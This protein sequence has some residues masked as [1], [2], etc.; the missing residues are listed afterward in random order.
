[1]AAS[2][3]AWIAISVFALGTILLTVRGA[4]RTSSLS[5]FA[6]GNRDIPAA[7][8]GLSLT[9]Q[10]TSVATFVIN[11]GLVFHYGLAGLLGLGVAA[12]SGI[13]LGLVVFTARF[14]RVGNQ[15]AALTVPQW[16]GTRFGS[17]RLRASF[18]LLSL[19]L[20][21]YAVLIVVAL[22]IVLGGLL[23]LE[24]RTVAVA[25]TV[26]VVS[27][28][29]IGG[30]NTHA[31][32]NAAQAVVMLGV[33]L[34]LIGWGLPSLWRDGGLLATI[35]AQDANLV[36]VT[37]P[38]SPYFRNLL[39]VFGCNFLVGLA[40]VCQP[41]IVSKALYLRDERQVRTFLGVAVVAGLVFL[42]V[43]VIG[44]Y[45]RAVVPVTTPIDEVVPAYIFLSFPP[46]LQVVIGVGL[47]CAGLSTL[48]GILLA[49][50]S[51]FSID[52]HPLLARWLPASLV[53]QGDRAALRFGRAALA[54]VAVVVILLARAQITN[55]TGGSVA[56]FAQYGVYLLFT[57]SFLPL[58]CGMFAPRLQSTWVGLGVAVSVLAYVAVAALQLTAMHNN[59]AFLASC[60]IVSGWAV[61]LTCAA[62]AWIGG[63][64]RARST[65]G[66]S[67]S[68]RPPALRPA[69]RPALRPALPPAPRRAAR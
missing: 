48:E 65:A 36:T 56:I 66:R 69:P 40:L 61:L 10:L 25:L 3:L 7:L 43:L 47:L 49:L 35:A 9:A 60:G 6:V 1:M 53:G 13:T 30:A 54:L 21:T 20:V 23:G 46:L 41:H 58:A 31:W 29:L 34:L 45:A 63:K 5:S 67:T 37:N 39:E 33:A 42:G 18:S 28:V 50:T 15:V 32:T 2:T 59:P 14:R 22:S 38:A 68:P 57:A 24:P 12:A 8:V 62:G 51:I 16:I 27:Y 4:L 52:V 17:Q 11:P 26:F 64:V 44:L 55:P 19:G